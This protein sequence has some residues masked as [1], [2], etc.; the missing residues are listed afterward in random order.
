MQVYKFG[1]LH[2]R[3]L[4]DQTMELQVAQLKEELKVVNE[5]KEK[6]LR[7]WI[8]K[9][10]ECNELRDKPTQIDMEAKAVKGKLCVI[11]SINT[12]TVCE[13]LIFSPIG[14]K[15]DHPQHIHW[16][17]VPSCDIC[18]SEFGG[19]N[20]A[21]PPLALSK[22]SSDVS[23]IPKRSFQVA[24]TVSASIAPTNS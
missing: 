13:K 8:K 23:T 16:V 11:V 1:N 4:D 17:S 12:P 3:I 24:D 2:I 19:I 21:N 5:E 22:S 6:L 14:V 7:E 18:L 15:I 9:D 20:S 10:K